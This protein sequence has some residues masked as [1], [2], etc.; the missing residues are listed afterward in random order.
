MRKTG[1]GLAVLS[2]SLGFA[3]A[4]V[5]EDHPEIISLFS[6]VSFHGRSY[7]GDGRCTGTF[8]H[9]RL[10]LTAAHC[11]RHFHAFKMNGTITRY[12]NMDN[13]PV[14]DET[15][16]PN[17]VYILKKKWWSQAKLHPVR[18]HVSPWAMHVMRGGVRENAFDLREVEQDLAILEFATDIAPGIRRI[19][20]RA[21]EPGLRVMFVG[22]GGHGPNDGG[23]GFGASTPIKHRGYNTL[24]M[25][26]WDS[27]FSNGDIRTCDSRPERFTNDWSLCNGD[28]GGPLI[29]R[30]TGEVIGVASSSTESDEHLPGRRLSRHIDLTSENAVKF[31]RQVVESLR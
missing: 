6:K 7:W 15:A 18:V 8:I 31:V 3:H 19:A 26:E 2:L 4:E 22:F 16:A 27:L 28:S 1:W 14:P 25:V 11:V 13:R 9:P 21:P 23:A 20:T 12:T 29:D 30:A 5:T 24:S 17:E 10:L